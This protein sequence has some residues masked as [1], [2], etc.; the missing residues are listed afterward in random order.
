MPFTLGLPFATC[1]AA[2]KIAR[3]LKSRVPHASHL[4]QEVYFKEQH[5]ST[6]RLIERFACSIDIRDK[7]IIDVGSGL[8]GR[9]PW[10][11]EHGATTVYCI[12]V[13]R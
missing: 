3:K 5:A 1:F 11:I 12:D 10:F 9:A 2:A 4:D 13:N 7:V 8:G 6:G